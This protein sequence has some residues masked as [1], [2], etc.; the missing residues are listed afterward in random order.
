MMSVD[1]FVLGYILIKNSLA[2][3]IY[4]KIYT[5]EENLGRVFLIFSEQDCMGF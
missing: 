3:V 1:F 2:I 4:L 5:L